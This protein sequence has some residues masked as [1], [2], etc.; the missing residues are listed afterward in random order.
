MGF[1][2]SRRSKVGVHETFGG[3]LAV[4]GSPGVRILASRVLSPVLASTQHSAPLERCPRLHP[5][6]IFAVEQRGVLRSIRAWLTIASPASSKPL[7]WTVPA[8]LGGSSLT[9]LYPG[10]CRRMPRPLC[11]HHCPR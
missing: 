8:L 1:R 10:I 3:V 9:H 11:H 7:P 4:F 6:R 5:G 2:E